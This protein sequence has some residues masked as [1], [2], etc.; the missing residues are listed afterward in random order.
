MT[1]NFDDC[2]PE[3][4][5]QTY[6]QKSDP[7]KFLVGVVNKR[8]KIAKRENCYT[9]AWEW[10]CATLHEVDFEV[11]TIDRAISQY[12]NINK[13]MRYSSLPGYSFEENYSS[14]SDKNY[15]QFEKEHKHIYICLLYTSPSPRDKRQSRMPS[16][17]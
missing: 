14:L 7:I 1:N 6:I 10:S 17:A 9:V 16:S 4:A 5:I 8:S 15:K 12:V 3:E 13:N 2:I 11:T